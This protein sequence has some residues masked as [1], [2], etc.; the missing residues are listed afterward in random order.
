MLRI[1]EL[2][3]FGRMRYQLENDILLKKAAEILPSDSAITFVDESGVI[4]YY[5]GSARLPFLFQIGMNVYDH[6]L[7]G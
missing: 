6:R 7:A 5:R 4:T 1:G 2:I 3:G